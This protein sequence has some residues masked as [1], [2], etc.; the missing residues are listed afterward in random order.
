VV[1]NAVRFA[2][3]CRF[4][5]LDFS[6]HLTKL[7]HDTL[8]MYLVLTK[9]FV[10]ISRTSDLTEM[11]FKTPGSSH[12]FSFTWASH[13]SQAAALRAAYLTGSASLLE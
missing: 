6:T 13:R 7:N 4:K 1:W 10:D 9:W 2:G 8:L 12:Y 3:Y 5:F 11:D